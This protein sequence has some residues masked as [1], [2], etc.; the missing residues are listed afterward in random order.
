MTCGNNVL[1]GRPQLANFGV[2]FDNLGYLLCLVLRHR[3]FR[4]LVSRTGTKGLSR[5][6]VVLAKQ[7]YRIGGGAGH[8][9]GPAIGTGKKSYNPE[10]SREWLLLPANQALLPPP[11]SR[12]R[13]SRCRRLRRK[14]PLSRYK[15]LPSRL[16]ASPGRE[17]KQNRLQNHLT[18]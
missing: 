4:R 17:S 7:A 10:N 1:R 16:P 12:C 6:L 13:T 8:I 3:G 5:V 9:G 15:P 14:V 18:R 11:R 2:L